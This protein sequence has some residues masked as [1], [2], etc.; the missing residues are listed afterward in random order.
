MENSLQQMPYFK[1]KMEKNRS[2][3]L[4]LILISSS[5][6][7]IAQNNWG[8]TR[9]QKEVDAIIAKY[10]N[11]EMSDQ[12]PIVFTG[13]SSIRFWRNVSELNTSETILNTG[14]GGSTALDLIHYI[15]PLVLK[16]NPK[17]VFV[18]EGDNDLAIGRS[19][20]KSKRHLKKVFRL[21]RKH[22]KNTKIVFIA[23][24]PSI[25]RWNLRSKFLKLNGK[26]EKMARSRVNLSFADVD[27]PMLVE[28]EINKT[29]FIDDGLHMN[30]KG[31]EIWSK[32]IRAF[33]N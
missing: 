16:Y 1:I 18:Y 26:I 4:F 27:T 10:E 17:Q 23:A 28:G 5:L 6:T 20:A 7:L 8:P 21:I 33:I 2:L 15:E 13:S 25:A 29:I 3:P 22:N 30:A 9:F 31:Y 24:K 32:V 11:T 12:A 14:F 19:V